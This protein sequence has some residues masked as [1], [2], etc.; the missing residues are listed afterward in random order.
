M[1]TGTSAP[2]C[3]WSAS[4]VATPSVA[5]P[6][7]S[8]APSPPMSGPA[9]PRSM[10]GTFIRLRLWEY[11]H[12][13]HTH[14]THPTPHTP[15]HA[16]HGEQGRAAGR[17]RMEN[18]QPLHSLFLLQTSAKAFVESMPFAVLDKSLSTCSIVTRL[19]HCHYGGR[20]RLRPHIYHAQPA[21]VRMERTGARHLDLLKLAARP[22]GHCTQ[23]SLSHAAFGRRGC[24]DGAKSHLC[25]EDELAAVTSRTQSHVRR[26]A[27]ERV[28]LRCCCCRRDPRLYR[29]AR[30]GCACHAIVRCTHA[31]DIMGVD[32]A[33]AESMLMLRLDRGQVAGH[34]RGLAK[35]G[36]CTEAQEVG[37]ASPQPR[38][39]CAR[40]S[41][42]TAQTAR[43]KYQRDSAVFGVLP[44][45]RRPGSRAATLHWKL[46]PT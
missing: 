32:T 11:T 12:V 23:R 8:F 36:M 1:T 27:A 38:P 22:P 9:P 7:T 30:P 24:P 35:A 33:R 19:E 5:P 34:L 44:A 6:P 15:H 4:A 3:G 10:V 2:E 41:A 40:A 29:H 26:G 31:Q 17:A 18:K 21:A 46:S 45:A 16:P 43:G 42:A 20:V 14:T 37:G 25:G 39:S 13:L 28:R